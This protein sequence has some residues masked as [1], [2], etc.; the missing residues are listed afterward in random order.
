[1]V[2]DL[3]PELN[4]LLDVKNKGI[5]DFLCA[6]IPIKLCYCTENNYG[7]FIYNGEA[8]ID[9]PMNNYSSASFTHELLHILLFVLGVNIGGAIKLQKEGNK[10]LHSVISDELADHITNILEHRK[11]FPIFIEL[12]YDKM[13]FLHDAGR[14]VLTNQEVKEFKT[15]FKKRTI[16]RRSIS[17]DVVDLYIGKYIAAKGACV[18]AFDYSPQLSEMY[19]IEPELCAIMDSLL[20][21]WGNYDETKEGDILSDS[22]NLIAYDFL[23]EIEDWVKCHNIV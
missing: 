4:K 3:Q 5:Y 20:S 18:G 15:L 8:R 19:K 7:V 6:K 22:Y 12:G 21:R 16:F 1:M 9:I 23:N 13:D 14:S 2:K 17:H 10:Y 11:M